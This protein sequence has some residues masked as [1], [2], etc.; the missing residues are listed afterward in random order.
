MRHTQLCYRSRINARNADRSLDKDIE[1]ILAS[2]RRHNTQAG[3]TGALLLADGYYFQILEGPA[4][5]VDTTYRRIER[6]NRHVEPVLL[7]R[8]LTQTRLFSDCPM[9]FSKMLS[10]P[11][12]RLPDLYRWHAEEPEAIGGEELVDMFS[13][14]ARNFDQRRAT[15]D[16]M[17]M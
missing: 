16:A 5:A 14:L 4:D 11:G 3:I 10:E 7:R 6:D 13:H 15:A 9:Y 17:M 8:R 1:R 2:A 12:P